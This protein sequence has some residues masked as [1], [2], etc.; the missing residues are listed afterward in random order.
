MLTEEENV[1]L[2]RVGPGTPCGDLLRR[3]W[4]PL[5]YVG[6]LTE[7][8][9]KAITVMGEDLVVFRFPD[10]RFGCVEEHCAH[11][12]AS[13]AYG[14]VEADGLRCA[15][16]GWKYDALGR[17]LEQPF[18]PAGSSY[19][20]HIQL[21]AYPAQAVGGLIFIYMGPTPAPVLPRWD[22]LV[23]TNGRRTIERQ[24]A[25]NCNWLQPMENTADVTHTY[26]LHGHTLYTQGRRDRALMRL[27][28]PFEK[29]GFQPFELGQVKAWHYGPTEQW[30]AVFEVGNMLIFPNI[31]RF[32]YSMHWRVPLDDT[33]TH[34]FTVTFDPNVPP[35]SPEELE[36]PPMTDHP[37]Q[38]RDDG[39]HSTRT[40][41]GQ[42][43]MA[44][45]T[46]GRITDRRKEHLGGS[47]RGILMLRQMLKDQIERVQ[48]GLDPIGVIR[49]PENEIVELPLDQYMEVARTGVAAT[50]GP[51]YDYLDD[52]QVWFEV[53]DG[54]ARRPGTF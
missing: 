41:W 33:H 36:N 2:T 13:L 51:M 45:E 10:G 5:G 52:R 54:A 20:D 30:P 44:W 35:A 42:D 7:E 32:A 50:G 46:Q 39:R 28:R 27:Y 34:V 19:K 16:H 43:R 49:D 8:P 21:R 3:Y 12:C 18:E 31:L 37:P 4:Q 38:Y 26:F 24:P 47:D 29:Y 1:L 48:Q 22:F 40:I 6:E 53:P 25:L 9:T 23:W 11:R 15:Y 17:C 14:F